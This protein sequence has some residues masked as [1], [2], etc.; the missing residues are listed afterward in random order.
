MVGRSTRLSVNIDEL[1]QYNQ[2][3]AT[4]VVKNPLQS[5]RMFQEQLNQTV[6]GMQDDAKSEK[7]MVQTD[8]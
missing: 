4:Y 5:I 7:Q 2:R 3:L 1:R 6:R 8:A